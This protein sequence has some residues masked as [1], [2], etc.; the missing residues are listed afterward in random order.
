M[1]SI[2]RTQMRSATRATSPLSSIQLILR[3]QRAGTSP[4]RTARTE[5]SSHPTSGHIHPCRALTRTSEP[6][7][8]GCLSRPP[9]APSGVPGKSQ[10]R[11]RRGERSQS[12]IRQIPGESAQWNVRRTF[13]LRALTR[14][15]ARCGSGLSYGPLRHRGWSRQSRQRGFTAPTPPSESTPLVPRAPG[16]WRKPRS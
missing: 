1:P 16:P 3:A 11:D 9:W 7:A 10:T 2:R 4:S 12:W 14:G 8:Q 13:G 15:I 5:S 6:A